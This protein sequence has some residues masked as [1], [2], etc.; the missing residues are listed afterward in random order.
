MTKM[1]TMAY[2]TVT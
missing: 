1:S 2:I